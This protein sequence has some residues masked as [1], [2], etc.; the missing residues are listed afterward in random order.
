MR[1]QLWRAGQ[2]V[3]VTSGYAARELDARGVPATLSVD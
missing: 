2:R 3:D 1:I